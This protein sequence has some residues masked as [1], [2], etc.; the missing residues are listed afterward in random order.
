MGVRLPSTGRLI[1]P[2]EGSAPSHAPLFHPLAL[3]A[4]FPLSPTFVVVSNLGSDLNYGGR[5]GFFLYRPNALLIKHCSQLVMS[6][7]EVL[8]TFQA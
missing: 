2:H 3:A 7:G 8:H 1:K 5:V 4:G 6:K